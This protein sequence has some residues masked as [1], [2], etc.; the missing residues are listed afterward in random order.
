MANITMQ[1]DEKGQLFLKELSFHQ[2]Q[3]QVKIDTSDKSHWIEVSQ[4]DL[5]VTVF[6]DSTDQLRAWVRHMCDRVG[7]KYAPMEDAVEAG[8]K[9]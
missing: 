3:G 1:A 2:S 8:V 6:F 4:G 9:P 7:V 5:A